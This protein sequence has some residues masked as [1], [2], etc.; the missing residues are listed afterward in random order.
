MK[1]SAQMFK[2]FGSYCCVVIAT[3]PRGHINQNV[4]AKLLP[5]DFSLY[6]RSLGGALLPLH[7]LFI[8]N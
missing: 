3:D 8:L 6:V 5:S 1:N 7:P 2:Y 4:S